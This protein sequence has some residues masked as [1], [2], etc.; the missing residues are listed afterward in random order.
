MRNPLPFLYC[1]VTIS[2]CD[3][4]RDL[5]RLTVSNNINQQIFKIMKYISTFTVDGAICTREDNKLSDLF[6]SIQMFIDLG[7]VV[8]HLQF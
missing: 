6:A 7:F 2:D 8:A 3:R 1:R 5:A 4:F